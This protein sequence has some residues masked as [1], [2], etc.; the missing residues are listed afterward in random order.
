MVINVTAE[1]IAKGKRGKCEECPI[2]L[3]L[4]DATKANWEVNGTHVYSLWANNQVTRRL[5]LEVA[6][7]IAR[8][9]E[10]GEMDPFT[11]EL[12]I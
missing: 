9:D 10:Q 11:F 6:N 8:F 1:H 7:R 3:A 12:P 2:A 4:N 5:P